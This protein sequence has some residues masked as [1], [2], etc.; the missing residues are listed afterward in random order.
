MSFFSPDIQYIYN[1]ITDYYENPL[2]YKIKDNGHL[3]LYGIQL[4]SLLLNEKYYLICM[5][6]LRH[7]HKLFLKEIPWTS[8]QVRTSEDDKYSDL[9]KIRYKLKNDK[10]YQIPIKIQSRNKNLSSYH[11]ENNLPL[12]VSLL[13]KKG[14]EYEYSD[15]GTLQTALE[16]HETILQIS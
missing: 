7:E 11:L 5:T 15:E 8:F 4:S 3:S 16:T 6:P 10:K 2:L 14:I 9:P 13:H 1:L 12:H